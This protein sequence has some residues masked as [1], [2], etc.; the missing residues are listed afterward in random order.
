MRE[1]LFT[2]EASFLIPD[3]ML[4]LAPGLLLHKHQIKYGDSVELRR[5]ET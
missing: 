5:P 2:A 4:V 3:R 1:Y